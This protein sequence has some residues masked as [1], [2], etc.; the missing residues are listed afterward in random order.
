MPSAIVAFSGGVDSTFVAAVAHDVLG[1]RT[2]VSPRAATGEVPGRRGQRPGHRRALP[3]LPRRIPSGPPA[4]ADA[5]SRVGRAEQSL[6]SLGIPQLRARPPAL[7]AGD[8]V[9]RIETDD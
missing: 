7:P 8:A 9:A 1:E 2:L 3:C 4:P 5:L 6:R